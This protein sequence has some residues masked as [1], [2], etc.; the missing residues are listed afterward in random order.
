MNESETVRQLHGVPDGA[1]GA[2]GR[3]NLTWAQVARFVAWND[4]RQSG[5]MSGEERLRAAGTELG[6]ELEMTLCADGKTTDVVLYR[7]GLERHVFSGEACCDTAHQFLRAEL[8]YNACLYPGEES[9]WS[10][11]GLNALCLNAG[12]Q[13]FRAFC[14]P[15]I[16]L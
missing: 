8:T 11:E 9:T 5:G 12:C 2:A 13:T 1:P 15:A 4:G 16:F 6:Y 7:P 14:E 10:P 3:L